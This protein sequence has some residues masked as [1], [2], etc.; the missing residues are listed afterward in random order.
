MKPKSFSRK[1]RP[2][3][4]RAQPAFAN[5]KSVG[6][7]ELASAGPWFL[8][9]F[10]QSQIDTVWHQ[11][12]AYGFEGYRPMCQRKKRV[13]RA[14]VMRP[15]PVFPNYM[16]VRR[17]FDGQVP[18]TSIHGIE[19]VFLKTI[20]DGAVAGLK[21]REIDGYIEFIAD[22]DP[23]KDRIKRGDTISTLD[24]LIEAVVHEV[25]DAKRVVILLNFMGKDCELTL[26]A[27]K[28]V[29]VRKAG[30]AA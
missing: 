3:A 4:V 15:A 16:F 19:W 10:R 24:G 5:V 7:E 2:D 11:L 23:A 30:D 27:A 12:R 8:V 9:Q 20:A 13:D 17:K 29:R 26:D 18:V 14:M 1:D 28:V 25:N 22:S 6:S 21:S